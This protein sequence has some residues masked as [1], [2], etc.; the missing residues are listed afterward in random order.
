MRLFTLNLILEDSPNPLRLVFS[1]EERAKAAAVHPIGMDGALVFHDDFGVEIRLKKEP[2]A[3]VLCDVAEE[4]NGNIEIS[5]LQARA[6]M[7]AQQK[8]K[9]DPTLNGNGSL[10]QPPSGGPVLPFPPRGA[11]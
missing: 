5:L 2:V 1:S 6:Q 8:A 7:K 9:S 4:L 10:W 3:R 11:A